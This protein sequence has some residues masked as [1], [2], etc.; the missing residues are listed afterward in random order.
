MKRIFSVCI[1]LLMLDVG[2]AQQS[3]N[4]SPNTSNSV[5]SGTVEQIR[6]EAEKGDAKA[7][8]RLG[9]CYFDGQGVTKD[10]DEAVKW[11]SKAAKQGN[12]AAQFILGNCY[13]NGIGVSKDEDEA[14]KW[15]RMASENP[16]QSAIVEFLRSSTG[17]L[18]AD[19]LTSLGLAYYFGNG[20]SQDYVEAVKWLQKAAKQRDSKAQLYLGRCYANGSGVQRDADE[21]IKW[22]CKSAEQG[23]AEAQEFLGLCYAQNLF[24]RPILQDNLGL[25]QD[26]KQAVKWFRRA[27]NQGNASAQAALGDC[28]M[29]GH[30][31]PKNQVEAYKWFNLAAAQDSNNAMTK[32][33][34]SGRTLISRNMT[35]GEIAEAQ[36]LSSAFVPRREKLDSNSGNSTLP[37]NPT[38]SGTGFFITDDG[39]LISNYLC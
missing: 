26:Y 11:L 3:T 7:Q 4:N 17:Q 18:D 30:G 32:I 35:A 34:E 39:Y 25:P 15:N 19:G 12:A 37:E 24:N 28:Y 5:A 31:V 23:E 33:G 27:A 14:A 9:M 22:F 16:D 1:F 2:A 20:V 29:D 36:Q 21:A 6:A 10:I 38:A 13:E 8:A